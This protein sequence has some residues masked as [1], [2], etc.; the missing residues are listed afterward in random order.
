VIAPGRSGKG[1]ISVVIP[2]YNGREWI[3][4]ALS[5]VLAQT[6]PP[7]E[8]VIVD[9]ASKVPLTLEDIRNIAGMEAVTGGRLALNILRHD[10]NRGI[11]AA[12][13]SGLRACTGEWI[14]FLDQDDEWMSERLEAQMRRI[15]QEDD[16]GRVGGIFSRV[17]EKNVRSGCERTMPTDT[18]IGF[19]NRHGLFCGLLWIGNFVHWITFMVR[20]RC[21]EDVGYLDEDLQGGSDDYDFI[22][23][24]AQRFDV[25]VEDGEPR[26]I[27]YLHGHNYSNLLKF[28]ND[29]EK[30]LSRLQEECRNDQM[31]VKGLHRAFARN[32]YNEGRYWHL[33]GD[34]SLARKL[35]LRSMVKSLEVKN[36]GMFL[37]SAC[38]ALV[39][40][41]KKP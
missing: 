25:L 13:N 38:A 21:L 3:S 34:Y 30:I 29:N 19:M 41:R 23:R 8:I 2:F 5:S 15:D 7:D 35:Y 31:L 40:R 4:R 18:E 11:P 39:N 36:I 17:L 16:P 24:I 14:A 37:I 20:R 9:D 10:V 32:L 1:N 26:A 22:L 6:L 28:A 12:R 27:H 33:R